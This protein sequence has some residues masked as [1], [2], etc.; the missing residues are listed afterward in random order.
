MLTVN[1]NKIRRLDLSMLRSDEELFGVCDIANPSSIRVLGELMNSVLE[2]YKNEASF[3][4][5]VN[6]L[7]VEFNRAGYDFEPSPD[8]LAVIASEGQ[9]EVDFPLY[10]R[11]GA[12]GIGITSYDDGIRS[13][14][15]YG[16]VLRLYFTNI[17]M[18][19]V[20]VRDISGQIVPEDS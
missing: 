4:D 9:G 20:L 11:T 2:K 16:L 5:V 13:K 6:R 17:F 1:I 14:L 18:G 8:R 10:A 12:R 7:R 19:D 15:G 3:P